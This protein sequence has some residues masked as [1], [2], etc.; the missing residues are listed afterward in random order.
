MGKRVTSETIIKRLAKVLGFDARTLFFLAHT[1]SIPNLSPANPVLSASKRF[2]NDNLLRRFHDISDAEIEMLS[3]L[4]SLGEVRSAREFIYVL[5]AVRLAI[6]P[7]FYDCVGSAWDQFKD[8]RLLRRIYKISDP[9]MRMLSRVASLGEVRSP[10]EFLYVLSAVRQVIG[11]NR[12][13][14]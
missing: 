2:K 6:D 12:R 5:N 9:E 4:V 10:R 8:D 14:A 11:A 3:H 1:Y 7:T 13:F